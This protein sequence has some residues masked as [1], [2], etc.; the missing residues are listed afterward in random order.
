MNRFSKTFLFLIVFC[1]LSA[2]IFI[3]DAKSQVSAS[4]C[5]NPFMLIDKMDESYNNSVCEGN[6]QVYFFPVVADG[7]KYTITLHSIDGEQKLFASRYKNK[8]DTLGSVLSWSCNSPSCDSSTEVG[9]NTRIVAFA[10][11]TGEESYYSWF[12]VYGETASKYQIGVSNNGVL[13]YIATSA[14]TP[15]P[16]SY[17]PNNTD[18]SS[19]PTPIPS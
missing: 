5:Y 4:E 16:N 18:N 3:Y 7:R 19:T 13:M 14:Y 17:A 12:A 2:G 1:A 6:F 15:V 10:S 8:V 9:E 11:P